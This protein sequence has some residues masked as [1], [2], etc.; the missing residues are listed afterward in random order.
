MESKEQT[1][2]RLFAPGS[3]HLAPMV[4]CGTLPLRLLALRYGAD[5]VYTE[6]LIDKKTIATLR[7]A[8]EALGTTDYRSRSGGTLVFRTCA[9]EKSR[10]VYQL[11]TADAALA[12][13]AAQTVERDV[14]VV[15]INMGCPKH[16]SLSGG[17]GAAL[18]RN[19]PVATDILKTLRR[20]LSVPV[21]CKVRLLSDDRRSLELLQALE[22]AGAMAIAVHAREVHERFEPAHWERLAALAAG[23][24]VPLIANGDVY[25]Y[26]DAQQLVGVSGFTGV[27][28]AR[29]ALRNLSLFRRRP[30]PPAAA[31][32]AAA[33]PLA[34]ASAA[35]AAG[36]APETQA[37]VCGSRAVGVGGGGGGR[38]EPKREEGEEEAAAAQA[39]PPQPQLHRTT[40]MRDYLV[41]AAESGNHF[42]NTKYNVLRMLSAREKLPR[43]TANM[44]VTG[45]YA[46]PEKEIATPGF[47]SAAAGHAKMC[48]LDVACER[49]DCHFSHSGTRP[50]EQAAAA[51][52]PPSSG[53]GAPVTAAAAQAAGGWKVSVPQLCSAKGGA[54]FYECFGA[55]MRAFYEA[56]TARH[57]A[58]EARLQKEIEEG[59][60]ARAA[61]GAAA[62]AA[63]AAAAGG[64]GGAAVCAVAGRNVVGAAS[65]QFSELSADAPKLRCDLCGVALCS[66]A[67]R[68][69]H[70]KGRK[71][72]HKVKTARSQH[73]LQQGEARQA[74]EAAAAV[75]AEKPAEEPAR[76]SAK[77]KLG[78]PQEAAAEAAAAT[79]T[80]AA[81][82]AAAA[83][84]EDE[85]A[86][87]EE[88]EG[89]LKKRP[90]TATALPE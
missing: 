26:E 53:G 29:G 40:V 85:G 39:A 10:V 60:T 44:A 81:A 79:A 14:A 23:V 52:P 47:A 36:A 58:A 6:E 71:H 64:G 57:A 15:D 2:A 21:T 55:E 84:Q 27:M 8:N 11:G 18:L 16:F 25:S 80:G 77:V 87:Q 50:C 62:A 1:I 24:G 37:F 31:A 76:E 3:M 9:E 86:Q 13:R 19:L 72:K 51:A 59:A 90:K 41:L 34:G 65:A 28:V 83:A 48:A 66:E 20:E 46:Q 88:E 56:T 68:A 30:W 38:G 75:A 22:Q 33:E 5:S 69:L 89:P 67:D 17:M 43:D 4:R 32:A 61:P 78:A 7:V 54:A 42:H 12:L 74:A 73:A 82:A 70:V 35:L 49:V 45:Y 63:V